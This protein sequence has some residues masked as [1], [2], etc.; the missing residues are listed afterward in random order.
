MIHRYSTFIKAVNLT[1]DYIILNVSMVI[2]YLIEDESYISWISNKSYLPVVL[3][4]NLIWLLSANV[5]GLYEHV[6]N[7][8]SIRT[9]RGLIKTYLLFVSFICFTIIILIGTKAY[10]ITR[11]YLF[12]SLAL[13]GFLLG[14]WKLIFLSIRRNDRSMLLDSRSAIIIGS[15]RIGKDLENYFKFNPSRGYKVIGFFDDEPSSVT[16]DAYLGSTRDCI[17]YVLNNHVDEI[18]CTLPS[19]ESEKIE[20]LMLDADKNLIRFKFIPDYYDY[21]IK[22]TLIQSFGH[23]P[24]IS[25]R[26]EPLENILNRAIKRVFD[27]GFSLFIILFVFSWLFPILALIIKIQSPG[28]V[29]FVQARSGR[30]NKSFN[31]YKFRS[32]KVNRDSDKKQA[33]RDDDRVTKIGKFMRKTSLD[34]LPQFFNVLIG[35]MSVVG[36]RPHMLSHTEQYSLLIDK[37]MVRHFLK[38]GI[39]GWAQVRG[40]RGETKT[41]EDMQARVEADV[42]YLENWSFLLD[43]KIIF[44]TLWNSVRGDKNAF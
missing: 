28:P 17:E 4:F 44:L 3:V 2:A 38:P 8:D 22:P 10:F 42:W 5:T 29:F 40:L 18:F 20:R 33:T 21:G 31:C 11:E 9:Y 25:I 7:K 16:K 6:L 27:I 19:S 39:T 37:F 26:P 23:I 15:G 12:Y 32:M 24:V 30:D 13:F 43:M 1:I 14:F 34:E 41:T 36:P 35:N